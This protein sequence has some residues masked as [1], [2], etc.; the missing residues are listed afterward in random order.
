[1]LAIKIS[2]LQALRR[3]KS[4]H[5]PS[6]LNQLKNRNH[7][8]AI[9]NLNWLR[10]SMTCTTLPSS[11]WKCGP[12]KRKWSRIST[13]LRIPLSNQRYRNFWRC[14]SLKNT[15]KRVVTENNVSNLKE[16]R[17]KANQLSRN[18]WRVVM[19][20][21]RQRLYIPRLNSWLRLTCWSRRYLNTLLRIRINRRVHF[22][23]THWKS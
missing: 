21:N 3:S 19:M 23:K 9:T 22:L 15:P 5:L 1:M 16:C 12:H 18:T 20:K 14:F 2:F 6:S 8:Q 13:L 10:N 4:I 17:V 7:R 11:F